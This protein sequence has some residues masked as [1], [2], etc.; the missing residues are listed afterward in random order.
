[1]FKWN[2]EELKFKNMK[3]QPF[4]TLRQAF[5]AFSSTVSY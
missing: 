1:M 5:E 3:E 2:K 4:G